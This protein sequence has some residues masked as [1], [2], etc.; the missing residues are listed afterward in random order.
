MR[1]EPWRG[2]SCELLGRNSHRIGNPGASDLTPLGGAGRRLLPGTLTW[3][4]RVPG[5]RGDDATSHLPGGGE[6]GCGR[7]DDLRLAYV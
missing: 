6:V 3:L 5:K 1:G 2:N 7:D 4:V